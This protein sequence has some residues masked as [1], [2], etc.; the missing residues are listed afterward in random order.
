MVIPTLYL[1]YALVRGAYE[2]V[3]AYPF[4]DLPKIGVAAT[5]AYALAM[6][7][8]FYITGWLMIS[9][10]KWCARDRP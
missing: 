1:A 7:I 5:S 4:L 6:G 10:D 8:G 2:G 9:W 3:Y